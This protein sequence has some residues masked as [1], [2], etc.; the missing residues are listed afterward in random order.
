MISY[1][2]KKKSKGDLVKNRVK[3]LCLVYLGILLLSGCTSPTPAIHEYRLNVIL[4]TLTADQTKC[5]KKTLKV[6]RAFSDKLSMSLKMYYIEG[7]YKQYAY[8]Q[9]QWVQSP[10]DKVTQ[11]VTEYIRAMQLFK[12]V[13]N[14]DSKTKNDFTLELNLEDFMQYF[15]KNEKNSY[16]NLVVTCNLIDAERHTVYRTKTF[17]VRAKAK[18]DD[19][20]GGVEALNKTLNTFL[21]E[22]SIWL[23]GVCLDK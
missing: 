9:S 11:S 5:M 17:R 2:K 22:C 8:S 10:N 19:A 18:S 21:Q 14:A 15:D 13:Q 6:D 1:L 23:R 16:V 12:S 7:K 3:T 20:L 4:P